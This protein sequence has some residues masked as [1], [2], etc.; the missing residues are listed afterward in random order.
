MSAQTNFLREKVLE[1][2]GTLPLYDLTN[3]EALFEQHMKK[4]NKTLTKSRTE[5]TKHYLRFVKTL[6]EINKKNFEGQGD[7]WTVQENADEVLDPEKVVF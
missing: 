1:K 4:Y 2:K 6:A 5:R 3:A 7:V